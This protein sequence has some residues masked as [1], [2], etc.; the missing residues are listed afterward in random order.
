MYGLQDSVMEFKKKKIF[1]DLLRVI[2]K[3]KTFVVSYLVGGSYIQ[4]TID[5]VNMFLKGVEG[6]KMS[7]D[8]VYIF[9]GKEGLKLTT[10]S[11]IKQVKLQLF[12][13][14]CPK[15]QDADKMK[16]KELNGDPI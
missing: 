16:E 4:K 7:L 10:K 1:I 2:N 12:D 15:I 9:G 13:C 11:D 14:I 8:T 3:S 6:L 5:E